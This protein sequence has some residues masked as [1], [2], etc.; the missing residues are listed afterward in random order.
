MMFLQEGERHT[1]RI[2]CDGLRFAPLHPSC[3]R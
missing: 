2:N 3:Q 1:R